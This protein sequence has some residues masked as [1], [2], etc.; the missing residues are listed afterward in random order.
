MS[1][2]IKYKIYF[3]YSF[4]ILLYL[5][6]TC[7]CSINIIWDFSFDSLLIFILSLILC[8]LKLVTYIKFIICVIKKDYT[9]NKVKV[10]DKRVSGTRYLSYYLTIDTSNSVFDSNRPFIL[11]GKVPVS[12][13]LYKKVSV[14]DYITVIETKDFI[15]SYYRR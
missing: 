13:L 9:V 8:Y 11:D 4:K 5:S 7:F 14:G 12:W 1:K 15:C 10:F 3:E 6:L 2:R